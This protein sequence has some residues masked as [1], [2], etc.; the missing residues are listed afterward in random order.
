[1]AADGFCHR[2]FAEPGQVHF[3]SG[4]AQFIH[5]V[6][7]KTAGV[8]RF[9]KGGQRIQQKGAFA[10]FAN[11]HAQPREGGQLIPQ[12]LGIARRE[13]DGLRQQQFLRRRGFVLF[14]TIQHLFKQNPLMCRVLIQQHQA[15][16]RFQEHIEL[17]HHADEAQGNIEQ[18]GDDGGGRRLEVGGGVSAGFGGSAGGGQKAH[19]QGCLRGR[20]WRLGR[21]GEGC[22]RP[23]GSGPICGRGWR[24][25]GDDCRG[26]HGKN[27]G[28][29]E[30]RGRKRGYARRERG[31]GW[32][33]MER[34]QRIPDRLRD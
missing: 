8:G 12:E 23:I 20:G 5:E 33:G 14:Q 16:I 18:G 2:V 24:N 32:F 1:M 6:E 22:A 15:A 27:L 31:F 28:L 19:F 29:L 7:H 26:L 13:L 25:R 3:P 17:A 11:A 21:R 4:G 10:K 30:R 34:E 9:D